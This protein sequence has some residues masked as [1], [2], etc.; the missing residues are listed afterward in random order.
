MLKSKSVIVV[1]MLAVFLGA[2]SSSPCRFEDYD[3]AEA[4]IDQRLIDSFQDSPSSLVPKNTTWPLKAKV[5]GDD[6]LSDG[7]HRGDLLYGSI[8]ADIFDSN[9][10]VIMK[11]RLYADCE[12]EWL[13]PK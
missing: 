5:V 6:Y 12:I 11:A 3:E 8:N 4:L 10:R 1:G 2:C 7:S 13:D 9:G